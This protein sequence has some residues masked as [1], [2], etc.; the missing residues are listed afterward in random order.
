MTEVLET[1]PAVDTGGTK[2]E[3]I[4]KDSEPTAYKAV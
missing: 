1:V 3:N 4:V 2:Q